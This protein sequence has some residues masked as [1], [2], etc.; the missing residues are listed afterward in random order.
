[1][2]QFHKITLHTE[3]KGSVGEI[4]DHAKKSRA[5]VRENF[6]NRAKGGLSKYGGKRGARERGVRA[7]R[8]RAATSR[9]TVAKRNFGFSWHT[10]RD[11]I[12]I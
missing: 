1:M 4:L 9:E 11:D 7:R 12:P 6:V 8:R 5:L 3:I 10:A 2:S